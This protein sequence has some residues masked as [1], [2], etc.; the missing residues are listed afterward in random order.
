MALGWPL[1][2]VHYFC[3]L[4]IMTADVLETQVLTQYILD[5]GSLFDREFWKSCVTYLHKQHFF[6]FGRHIVVFNGYDG[7]YFIKDMPYRL[8]KNIED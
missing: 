1:A 6:N 8:S 5:G 2:E 4:S 7:I 3:V